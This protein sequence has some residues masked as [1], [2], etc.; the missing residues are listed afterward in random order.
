MIA[1]AWP[2][3]ARCMT[4]QEQC[5]VVRHPH[6]WIDLIPTHHPDDCQR[7]ARLNQEMGP[8]LLLYTG[9]AHKLALSFKDDS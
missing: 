3:I 5:E 6:D 9:S 4:Q 1:S 2:Q 8:N 7:W